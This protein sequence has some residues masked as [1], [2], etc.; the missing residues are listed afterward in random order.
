M[1]QLLENEPAPAIALAPN[2]EPKRFLIIQV[3][4]N[5]GL[6]VQKQCETLASVEDYLTDVSEL[7]GSSES[8]WVYEQV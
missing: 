8:F 1:L 6:I 7:Y 3:L 2:A 5:D 4:P